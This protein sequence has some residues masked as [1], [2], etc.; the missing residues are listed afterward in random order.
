MKKSE[1]RMIGILVLITVIVI[2]IYVVTSRGKEENIGVAEEGNQV[3][4]E[5]VEVLEDGTRLNT[6]SKLQ[7]TKTID[8]MEVTNL[9]LTESGDISLLLG[10]VRNVSSEAKGGYPVEIRVVDKE[11]NEIVTVGGYIPELAPGAETQL[12]SSATFDYANAY[13]FTITKK[14]IVDEQPVEEMPVE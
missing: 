12:N 11:E 2:I 14:D 3:V 13:D 8:G 7:E 1:K 6:S 10:T 9:Q 5:F 4:E